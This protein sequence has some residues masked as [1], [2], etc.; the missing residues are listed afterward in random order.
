[1]QVRFAAVP[2]CVKLLLRIVDTRQASGGYEKGSNGVRT[3]MLLC[4]CHHYFFYNKIEIVRA[5]TVD[6]VINSD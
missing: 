4:T 3:Y 5:S 2:Y 6:D 1:M